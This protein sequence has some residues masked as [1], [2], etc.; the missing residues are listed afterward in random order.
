MIAS[1]AVPELLVG[2]VAVDRAREAEGRPP[3]RRS[4]PA[5]AMFMTP[6]AV[7]IVAASPAGPRRPRP[8]SGPPCLVEIADAIGVSATAER[9]RHQ[10]DGRDA[11]TAG[12]ATRSRYSRRA[13]I[14][15]FG[16]SGSRRAI[17]PRPRRA[18]ST[19]VSVLEVASSPAGADVSM[20]I[21]SSDGSATSKRRHD[22]RHARAP[23]RGRRAAPTPG[24]SS[25]S[26]NPAPGARPATPSID[27][28]PGRQRSRPRRRGGPSVRA[29][30]P[31]QLGERARRDDPAAIHDHERLAQR[32]GGLHLVG[33]ED[34]R[35][36]LVAQLDERLA[37]QRQVDRI[38]A[39]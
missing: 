11:G 22:A 12:C 3:G 13:T 16:K 28:E 7:A 18:S 20:K 9:E 6:S 25:S 38:E 27:V 15:A 36:A 37:Q 4:R 19:R 31:L 10:D 30:G 14:P 23:R 5:A 32:L 2:G 34:D 24:V 1:I 39:R 17:R 35:P 29:A 26:V 8:R 21:A 33:R